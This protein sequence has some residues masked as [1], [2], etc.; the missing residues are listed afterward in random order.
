MKKVETRFKVRSYELDSFGHVNHAVYVQYLEFARSEMF[1][2]IGFSMQDAFRKGIYPVVAN[3]TVNYRKELLLHDEVLL[4]CFISKIGRSSFTIREEGYKLT[5]GQMKA[6]DAEVV[7][8]FVDK[9]SSVSVMIP[10]EVRNQ[11]QQL[12]FS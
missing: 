7:M 2:S 11:F 8:A 5:N 3:L 9:T 1:R 10:T 12:L 4:T 6:F